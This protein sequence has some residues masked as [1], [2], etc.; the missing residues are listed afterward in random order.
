MSRFHLEAQDEL[1]FLSK[2]ADLVSDF[3]DV[4]IKKED[5]EGET[6]ALK[7]HILGVFEQRRQREWEAVHE[8]FKLVLSS[9]SLTEPDLL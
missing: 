1:V 6:D 7:D 2:A 9:S 5:H 4:W 3:Q 8:V